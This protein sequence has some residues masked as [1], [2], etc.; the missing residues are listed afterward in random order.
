[1]DIECLAN[2][3]DEQSEHIA[4]VVRVMCTNLAVPDSS[5]SML[6]SIR[7]TR[8]L[9]SAVKTVWFATGNSLRPSLQANLLDLISTEERHGATG[10]ESSRLAALRVLDPI[11]EAATARPGLVWTAVAPALLAV[12]PPVV[13]LAAANRFLNVRDPLTFRQATSQAVQAINHP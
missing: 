8:A 13:P 12:R 7:S 1:M 10:M 11:V 3:P 6:R 2:I 4:Q 9:A 5:V